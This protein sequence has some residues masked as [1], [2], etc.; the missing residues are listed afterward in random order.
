MGFGSYLVK[1]AIPTHSTKHLKRYIV[2]SKV[3]PRLP[4]PGLDSEALQEGAQAAGGQ[5]PDLL[6]RLHVGQEEA[7]AP[8]PVPRFLR[9]AK[10]ANPTNAG[11][12]ATG[13]LAR[14]ENKNVLFCF[15]KLSGRQ[16]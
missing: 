3:P 16:G 12:N 13:S 1:R 7:E 8:R 14:F 9:F 6:P 10:N 2:D 5:L 4:P 11:Y 15:E